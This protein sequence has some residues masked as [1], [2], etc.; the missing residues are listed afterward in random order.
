MSQFPLVLRCLQMGT[1]A[2]DDKPGS[3]DP[4]DCFSLRDFHVGSGGARTLLFLSPGCPLSKVYPCLWPGC[5]AGSQH[6]IVLRHAHSLGEGHDP[7]PP[8][9][10]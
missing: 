3:C 2:E 9:K 4:L 10:L 5:W 8:V 6:C 7:A 1:D